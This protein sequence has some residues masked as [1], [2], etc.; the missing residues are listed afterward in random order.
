MAIQMYEETSSALAEYASIPISF[1]VR[2][3]FCVEW[4]DG[5]LGGIRFSEEAVGPPYLKDYD[6]FEA[7]A[8]WVRR[9]DTSNWG[10]F[11]A[12]EDGL[13]IGGAVVAWRTP[14]LHLLEGRDDL[15]VL[16]DIRVATERRRRGVGRALVDHAASWARQRQCR[17]LKIETQNTNVPACRFYAAC[18][19]R[20]GGIRPG[21][22]SEFPDEVMLL[23]YQDL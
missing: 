18:G 7:P 5:G 1:C 16:W 20:L 12:R 23:W 22:Y 21:A 3:R 9:F 15:A 2:S 10:F 17:S 14:G 13:P 4:I 6:A 11:L 19:C 8:T